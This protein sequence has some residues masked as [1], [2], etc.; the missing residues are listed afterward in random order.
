MKRL[1]V[2][3]AGRGWGVGKALADAVV[4]EAGRLGYKAIVLDTL[5]SMAPAR[6]L[7]ARLGFVEVAAYYQSPLKEETAFLRL[8]LSDEKAE[9]IGIVGPKA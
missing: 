8:D 5:H 7:Y 6:A 4:A 9:R 2:D 1:Y 3:P